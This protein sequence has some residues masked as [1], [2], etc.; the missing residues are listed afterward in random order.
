MEEP[1]SLASRILLDPTHQ[2]A[3][4]VTTG[5]L[6]LYCSLFRS[7]RSALLFAVVFLFTFSLWLKG[8]AGDHKFDALHKQYAPFFKIHD[9]DEAK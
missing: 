6:T 3:I 4:I 8:P 9:G 5:L 2:V 1:L 7:L